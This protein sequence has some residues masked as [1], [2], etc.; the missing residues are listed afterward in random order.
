VEINTYVNTRAGEAAIAGTTPDMIAQYQQELAQFE[1]AT[2]LDRMALQ[3]VTAER[4][5]SEIALERAEGLLDTKFEDLTTG[6]APAG[7]TGTPSG[8][9]RRGGGAGRSTAD[10]MDQAAEATERAKTALESYAE[11]AMKSGENIEGALAGAFTTAEKALGDFIRT[12][13][14]DFRGFVTSII[15]DLAMVGAMRFILGPIANALTGAL[16]GLGGG[17]VFGKALASVLHDGGIV[18]AGGS[19]RMVPARAFAGAPRFH[20]GGG[21]GLRSDEQAAILQRGERVLSRAQNRAWEGGAGAQINIY[22]RDAQSF[23][24]SRKQVAT[25]IARAVSAGRRGM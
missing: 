15:A 13:K 11:T 8:G 6:G 22:A 21:F 9:G 25:D 7:G 17:G 3:K 12:G 5:L 2:K 19:G 4:A 18:G 1:E 20:D 14:V 24:Q 23:R 16:G 10:G